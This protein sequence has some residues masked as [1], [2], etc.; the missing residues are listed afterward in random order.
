[1]THGSAPGRLAPNFCPYCAEDDLRPVAAGSHH[2]RAC[3]R[4]FALS[5]AGHGAGDHDDDNEED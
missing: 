3:D 1:V 4:R 2:C 5:F